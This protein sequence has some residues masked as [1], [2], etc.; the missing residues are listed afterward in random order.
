MAEEIKEKVNLITKLAEITESV[1]RIPKNGYNAF[2]KYHYMTESDIK[3]VVR[4]EMSKRNIVIIGDEI[5]NER[6]EVKTNKGNIEN[7]IKI[8]KE[9]SVYDGDSGEKIT[10]KATG[11]GQDSGDKAQYKAETGLIKYVL[12][13]LFLI[14]SGDDPEK[15]GKQLQ[16]PKKINST[17][18]SI[19]KGKVEEFAQVQGQESHQV[20]LQLASYLK[21]NN[22]FEH[23]TEDEF[24][25][26]MN[27]FNSKLNNKNNTEEKRAWDK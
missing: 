17:Q 23:L 8:T 21:I 6:T 18:L 12:N 14:P 5:S 24:G 3:E 19:V 10:F 11:V 13:N 20:Y 16:P 7:Q 22:N 26:L 4:E 25:V 15:E 2:H 9:M 27:Y 1:K